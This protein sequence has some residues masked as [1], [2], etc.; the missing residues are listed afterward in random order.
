VLPNNIPFVVNVPLPVPPS[1]TAILAVRP[2]TV[3]P[4]KLAT[5]DAMVYP[6]S[7]VLIVLPVGLTV[8]P[9]KTLNLPSLWSL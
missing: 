8:E 4:V 5:N 3:P 1:P 6:E 7:E 2:D 9:S